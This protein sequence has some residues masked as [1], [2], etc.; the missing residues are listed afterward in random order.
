MSE[1]AFDRVFSELTDDERHA[2]HAKAEPRTYA[3]G[4]CVIEE[5][6]I[7]GGLF[8]ITLGRVRATRGIAATMS[9]EFA[10]PLGVGEVIGEMS[11]I[12]GKPT[13]ATLTA[14]GDVEVLYLGQSEVDAMLAADKG[15]A[16]RFYHSLLMTLVGRLRD[17]NVRFLL[18]FS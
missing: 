13:S 15:F 10:G 5:N 4:D 7:P 1:T 12:D 16:T 2:L 8:V 11:F 9:A 6:S 3:S 18:P 14:D 17:F